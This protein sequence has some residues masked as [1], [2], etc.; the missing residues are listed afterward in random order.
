MVFD[1]ASKTDRWSDRILRKWVDLLNIGK[2]C[3]IKK[4]N[5][6]AYF[7]VNFNRPAF[8]ISTKYHGDYFSQSVKY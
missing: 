1:G 3:K 7:P 5:Y 4:K 6:Q 8:G 2:L